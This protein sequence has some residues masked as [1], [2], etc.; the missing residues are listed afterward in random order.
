MG[1]KRNGRPSW[2]AEVDLVPT[3]WPKKAEPSTTNAENTSKK[4]DRHTKGKK[5]PEEA[6]EEQPDGMSDMEWM[7][8]KMQG[9]SGMLDDEKAFEQ[10]DEEAEEENGGVSV[11]NSLSVIPF[12][13]IAACRTRSMS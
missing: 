12:V 10:S 9:S 8:R 1:A 7:R 13:L 4:K 3:G 5:K 6:K 11:L 2:A